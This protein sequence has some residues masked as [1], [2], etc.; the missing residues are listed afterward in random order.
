[1]TLY[2]ISK[3]KG[4]SGCVNFKESW[5]LLEKEYKNLSPKKIIIDSDHPQFKENIN[6]C[7][8]NLIK[9][10]PTLLFIK[11]DKSFILPIKKNS[12]TENSVTENLNL[13]Y[14][15]EIKKWINEHNI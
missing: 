8:K 9:N 5:E 1:M 12:V 10:V 15:E 4:C 3:N 2:L 14:I 6:F 11:D 7:K 13:N